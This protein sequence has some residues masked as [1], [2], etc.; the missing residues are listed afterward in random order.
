[1]EAN[2]GENTRVKEWIMNYAAYEPHEKRDVEDFVDLHP[3]WEPIFRKAK[4]WERVLSSARIASS[5]D[6]DLDIL[7][8]A[9]VADRGHWPKSAR[10]LKEFVM[11]LLTRSDRVPQLAD[12]RRELEQ[13]KATLESHTNVFEH[14]QRVTGVQMR[15]DLVSGS[16]FKISQEHLNP[17]SLVH[18]AQKLGSRIVR[19]FA[20]TVGIYL[21]LFA[22]STLR[23]S[24]AER[25]AHLS[26][27]DYAWT[28]LGVTSRGS[29]EWEKSMVLRYNEALNLARSSSESF[30]GLFPSYD[31]S[32][33]RRARDVLK[34]AMTAQSERE[35]VPAAAYR[36][37][38]KIHFL[39]G[40]RVQS[41][42]ALKRAIIL[43][44]PSVG[45]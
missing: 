27:S 7:P 26:S 8:Y 32:M 13:R 44:G 38:A 34:A 18:A 10:A 33:L 12:Y 24:P 2:T 15:V 19:A 36:T 20:L 31:M 40:E 1:M 9:L 35:V 39:L 3:E 22:I 14:F 42:D 37:L 16:L 30:M 11:R 25:M 23:Q 41:L 28:E 45:M 5:P 6:H 29:A 4:K 21:L 43:E 17:G